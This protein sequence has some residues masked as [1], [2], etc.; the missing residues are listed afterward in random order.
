MSDVATMRFSC[1]GCNKVYAWKPELAG[2]RVKCKCGTTIHIPEAQAPAPQEE[3]DM[4]DLAPSEEPVKPKRAP[5]VPPQ[6]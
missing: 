1:S 5:V 6:V 3:E 4:Y 2:K